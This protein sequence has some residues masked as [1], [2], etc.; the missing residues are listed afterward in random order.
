MAGLE[1]GPLPLHEGWG[2]G[3]YLEGWNYLM[4]GVFPGKLR[5]FCREGMEGWLFF[6]PVYLAEL[7]WDEGRAHKKWESKKP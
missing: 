7:V 2:C 3:S 5:S 6:F 4:A 1:H